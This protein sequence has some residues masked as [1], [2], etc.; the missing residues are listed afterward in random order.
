MLLAVCAKKCLYSYSNNIYL[1]FMVNIFVSN[2]SFKFNEDSLRQLF[3]DYGEIDSCKI[4]TD[5]FT[6]KSRG[7]GFVEMKNEEDAQKAINSLSESEHDGRNISVSV[8]K[9]RTENRDRGFGGGGGDRRSSSG[10][11]ERRNYD[12]KW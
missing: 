6:G 7:F 11:G 5:K 1:N 12:K 3:Q 9:P 8:A 4:I 10:G 2:L